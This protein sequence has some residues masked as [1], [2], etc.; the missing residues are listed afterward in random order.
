MK[1]RGFDI[2]DADAAAA[3][4]VAAAA[5]AAFDA[6]DILYRSSGMYVILPVLDERLKKR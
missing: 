3:I 4:V 1:V 5:D 6:A 2:D